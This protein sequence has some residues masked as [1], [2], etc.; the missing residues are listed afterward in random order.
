MLSRQSMCRE[1]VWVSSCCKEGHEREGRCVNNHGVLWMR[2]VKFICQKREARDGD[3]DDRKRCRGHAR[4][5]H[6]PDSRLLGKDEES[7]TSGCDCRAGGISKMR[8]RRIW[9]LGVGDC[10]RAE[11]D[12]GR[13]RRRMWERRHGEREAEKNSWIQAPWVWEGVGGQ[14]EDL[15]A[16]GAARYI[17]GC[18]CPRSERRQCKHNTEDQ[19]H[20]IFHTPDSF[21]SSFLATLL[22]R[23]I[24]CECNSNCSPPM[25]CDVLFATYPD[26]SV[27]STHDSDKH[28]PGKSEATQ[29]LPLASGRVSPSRP[30]STTKSAALTRGHAVSVF[31]VSALQPFS[32]SPANLNVTILVLFSILE[33]LAVPGLCSCTAATLESRCKPCSPSSSPPDRPYKSSYPIPAAPSTALF[34]S[35]PRANGA[36]L[37]AYPAA[38]NT[39]S[40]LPRLWYLPSLHSRHARH[41][42]TSRRTLVS[43][44]PQVLS[45]TPIQ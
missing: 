11:V 20:S 29:H 23:N 10:E 45:A 15:G 42:G 16:G 3:T 18:V 22:G 9:V 24:G 14:R 19:H 43:H 36:L 33:L 21:S 13:G 1:I 30:R 31:A 39:S 34:P 17:W 4:K 7:V 40:E 32:P 6:G 37:L 44:P 25:G 5:N 26:Q 38:W 12:D 41:H 8:A 28:I 2:R 27:A 35:P